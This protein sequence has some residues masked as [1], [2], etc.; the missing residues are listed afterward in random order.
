MYS[1]YPSQHAVAAGAYH[2]RPQRREHQRHASAS[3]SHVLPSLPAAIPLPATS[4][5][6]SAHTKTSS[7]NRASNSGNKTNAH[8]SSSSSSKA[9]PPIHS[10][11]I[12]TTRYNDSMPNYST[13]ASSA[14]I[15]SQSTR[16][17]KPRDK[18]QQQQ[19]QSSCRY[20]SPQALAPHQQSRDGQHYKLSK[21]MQHLSYPLTGGKSVSSSLPQNLD[22]GHHHSKPSHWY[23][24][25][26]HYARDSPS[27]PL[28]HEGS[29]SSAEGAGGSAN[30][31]VHS[32]Q[33]YHYSSSKPQPQ[34]IY[35]QK[36]HHSSHESRPRDKHHVYP[37][38]PHPKAERSRHAHNY[39][40]HQHI[41]RKTNPHHQHLHPGHNQYH[42][43]AS[44]SVTGT[45]GF[46]VPMSLP[47][48]S[49]LP[50]GSGGCFMKKNRH[51]KMVTFADP[52]AEFKELPEV[53]SMSA[54][55]SSALTSGSILKRNSLTHS[56]VAGDHGY[57]S[58]S[59]G[60]LLAYEQSI[61]SS[62]NNVGGSSYY[63]KS[64]RRASSGS[65]HTSQTRYPTESFYGADGLGSP[66][67]DYEPYHDS[68]YG[69]S[70]AS[71]HSSYYSP[72]HYDSR[73]SLSTDYLPLNE[74]YAYC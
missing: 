14:I 60:G 72:Y 47:D 42:G 65:M 1:T 13:S 37:T 3:S 38:S 35:P 53:C 43:S 55:V 16:S 29:G 59:G 66:D 33:A 21:R 22:Y 70:L 36:Q 18:Q 39:D 50:V 56:C 19:Q 41:S 17:Q 68:F 10:L 7:A 32:S 8:S 51:K 4:S 54:P 31:Y 12:N 11:T 30:Y 57:G 58:S 27:P 45:S 63:G 15:N 25:H 40:Q 28:N 5:A 74:D 6:K 26:S 71:Y 52:I 46:P 49:S 69:N 9:Y 24:E 73:F 34:N 48:T 20:N 67:Y 61:A 23:P 44:P 2:A 64:R 62:S